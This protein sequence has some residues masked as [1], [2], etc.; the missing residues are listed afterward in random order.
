ML[1][2]LTLER[3]L[4]F[5]HPFKHSRHVTTRRVRI[6]IAACVVYSCVFGALPLFGWNALDAR[7]AAA[8]A[9]A[10]NLCRFELML[11]GSYLGVLFL[12]HIVPPFIFLPIT[13]LHVFLTARRLLAQAN[14]N[15]LCMRVEPSSGSEAVPATATLKHMRSYRH[16]KI[17]MVM[18]V[19]FITSWMPISVWEAVLFEG[20]SKHSVSIVDFLHPP[21]RIY[22]YYIFLGLA[23]GNSAVNPVIF[24][25]GNR[26]IRRSLWS[27]VKQRRL[28][29]SDHAINSWYSLT[30]TRGR[31]TE[32]AMIGSIER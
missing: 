22:L 8:D 24:G 1:S 32:G 4:K 23:I 12:A 10:P 29:S 9:G 15:T 27:C 6:T 11:C 17:L 20:F 30:D 2:A 21:H 16:F 25:A 14:D 28:A 3:Y 26:S 13:Y 5:V 7:N 31:Q 18:G 19:Y